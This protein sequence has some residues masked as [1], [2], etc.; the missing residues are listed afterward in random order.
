MK[1]LDRNYQY[2]LNNRDN[3]V[4]EYYGRFVIIHEEKVVSN[5][6]SELKAYLEGKEEFGLGNFIIQYAVPED[7]EKL[8]AFC[9]PIVE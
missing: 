9:S 8:Q 7:E 6:D 3:I 1:S 2:F 4:R 5:H